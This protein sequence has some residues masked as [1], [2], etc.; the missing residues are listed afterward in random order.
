MEK[1]QS[2]VV[3]KHRVKEGNPKFVLYKNPLLE[4]KN[5]I[6]KIKRDQKK[7]IKSSKSEIKKV[8]NTINLIDEIDYFFNSDNR[9]YLN[10][11]KY[12][13]SRDSSAKISTRVNSAMGLL[14]NIKKRNNLNL[15]NLINNN[16]NLNTENT[17]LTNNVINTTK[18]KVYPLEINKDSFVSDYKNIKPLTERNGK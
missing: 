8:R 2:E 3:D 11:L 15:F 1:I 7:E 12:E 10:K 9:Q 5:Y 14:E 17:N 18:N 13:S 4:H 16:E 6:D